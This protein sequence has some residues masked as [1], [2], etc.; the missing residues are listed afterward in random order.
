MSAYFLD[1][2]K[3]YIQQRVLNL[4]TAADVAINTLNFL[5]IFKCERPALIS[6]IK[7]ASPSKGQIYFGS[8]NHLEIADAYFKNG[9][10]A[11]SILTEPNFF[12]GDISFLKDIRAFHPQ[13]HLLMKD[14]VLSSRQIDHGIIFGANA[15]LL[16]AAFLEKKCLKY[17]YKYALSL[18]ITPL[19]EVHTLEELKGVL[20]LNPKLIGINNR[21][22]NTLA[23]DL[24]TSREL[25]HLI[26][27]DCY[28][29]CES[30]I[31]NAAQ[32][33]EM[34]ELGFDGFLVGSS[35]MSTSN[36]G[37]ALQGLI[38]GAEHVG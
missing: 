14:F 36:Q 18:G 11:L 15:V 3:P 33:T 25:I 12:Q 38:Q 13:A 2:I 21:D 1:K 22:L 34:S 28:A 5:D 31:E 26:P 4:A 20:E 8:A 35:L 32:I 10:S 29:I 37:L 9:A 24:N 7:F 27:D 17:L 6:E 23:I 16:I 30:G 19:I